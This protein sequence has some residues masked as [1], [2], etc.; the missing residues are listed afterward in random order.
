VED[1]L[2]TA[3]RDRSKMKRRTDQA[4]L[5]ARRRDVEQAM[6]YLPWTIATQEKLADMHGVSARMIREDAKHVRRFHEEQINL[7]DRDAEK[8]NWLMRL[9]TAQVEARKDGQHGAVAR[10]Y[11]LEANVLGIDQ[12]VQVEVT[13]RADLLQ[14]IEQA[15]AIVSSYDE[16]KA[17][18]DAV[19]QNVIEA[20]CTDGLI[21]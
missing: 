5:E 21:D 17:Y 15:R 20:D 18:L 10:L 1:D 16:A 19:D 11:R 4:G 14:P 7:A 12:A 2:A 6:M 8:A 13:H 9:R 3:P